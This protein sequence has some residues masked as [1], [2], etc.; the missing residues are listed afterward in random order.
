MINWVLRCLAPLLDIVFSEGDKQFV[1]CGDKAIRIFN[2]IP[3]KQ[4]ALRHMEKQIGEKSTGAALK[5]RLKTEMAA[6]S[7]EIRPF[8]ADE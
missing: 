4:E 6:L 2:N 3:G 7:E 1:T 5:N 8:L